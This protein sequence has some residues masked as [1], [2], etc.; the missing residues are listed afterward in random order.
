[1]TNTEIQ[2]RCE[3]MLANRCTP[4]RIDNLRENEVFVFGAKPNG[5]H[6][7]GAAKIAFEKYGAEEG[8][9][10]GFSG[11]SYAIP[12]HKE[13]TSKMD[14]AVKEFVAFAKNNPDKYFMVL[15]VGCGKAGM[16]ARFVAEM[17][18]YAINFENI[19]LPKDFIHALIQN[20]KENRVI[21]FTNYPNYYSLRSQWIHKLEHLIDKASG[22]DPRLGKIS[23]EMDC[24]VNEAIDLVVDMCLPLLKPFYPELVNRNPSVKEV[25]WIKPDMSDISLAINQITEGWYQCI[26]YAL[27][28]H[29]YAPSLNK[30]DIVSILTYDLCLYGPFF[31]EFDY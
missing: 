1:M 23:V 19:W 18:S 12:V 16:E 3:Q 31:D 9:G 5:H 17:F 15:P 4:E 10:N 11:Q 28:Y 13:K 24:S 27:G 25:F 29:W 2:Q 21:Q 20:R 6:K 14:K 26:K 7:S 8:K 30:K 22:D